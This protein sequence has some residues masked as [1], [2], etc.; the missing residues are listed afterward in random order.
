MSKQSP[1]LYT[2]IIPSPNLSD[3]VQHAAIKAARQHKRSYHRGRCNVSF[4]QCATLIKVIVT[5]RSVGMYL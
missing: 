4:S 1:A 5:I 3:A 2:S